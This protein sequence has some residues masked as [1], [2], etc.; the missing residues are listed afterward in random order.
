MGQGLRCTRASR[1]VDR[2]RSREAVSASPSGQQRRDEL[3]G[4]PAL[5][6]VGR[7]SPIADQGQVG[8][9]VGEGPDD[10]G[11]AARREIGP[12]VACLMECFGQ[13][14]VVLVALVSHAVHERSDL[15]VGTGCVGHDGERGCLPDANVAVQPRELS[16][17]GSGIGFGFD[18]SPSRTGLDRYLFVLA[19][20][21]EVEDAFQDVALGLGAGVDGLDRYTGVL[22]DGGDRGRDV[23]VAVN[24]SWAAS[25][26]RRRVSAACR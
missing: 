11:R 13:S 23:A 25:K 1:T 5:I 8:L 12:D 18:L 15:G 6:V 17:L 21:G 26:I 19:A 7:P 20:D 4:E 24:N 22:S 3:I 2:S 14:V 9:F 16:Q 10:V